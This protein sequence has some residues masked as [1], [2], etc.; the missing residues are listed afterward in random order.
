MALQ[1]HPRLMN[2]V[3]GSDREPGTFFQTFGAD[4]EQEGDMVYHQLYDGQASVDDVIQLLQRATKDQDPRGLN[5]FAYVLCVL[6]EEKR[7]FG[8]SPSSY[9]RRYPV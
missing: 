8:A 2:F 1:L 5:F 9:L 6:F 3:P 4:V 7:F